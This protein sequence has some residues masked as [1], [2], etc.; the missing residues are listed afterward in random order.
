MTTCPYSSKVDVSLQNVAKELLDLGCYKTL[1]DTT[2]PVNPVPTGVGEMDNVALGASQWKFWLC[3]II[4]LPISI[5]RYAAFEFHDA[6]GKR[7]WIPIGQ[8]DT[9]CEY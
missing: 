5:E 1:W 8:D 2:G 4:L 7:V 6:F 9:L 3:H